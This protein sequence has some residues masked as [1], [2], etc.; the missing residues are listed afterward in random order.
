MPAIYQEDTRKT[1]SSSP[2]KELFPRNL[3]SRKRKNAC[4]MNWAIKEQNNFC[5][6]GHIKLKRKTSR[7]FFKIFLPSV[8]KE[9]FCG[10][11]CIFCPQSAFPATRNH[12][13]H[14]KKKM[15]RTRQEEARFFFFPL[16]PSITFKCEVDRK[17][18]GDLFKY[19]MFP[20][21]PKLKLKVGFR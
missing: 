8:P 2:R 16:F 10:Q 9:N 6:P 12:Q 3:I 15:S 19:V 21:L 14:G 5:R 7:Q 13:K 18:R 1:S 17:R 20:G 11:R 4:S